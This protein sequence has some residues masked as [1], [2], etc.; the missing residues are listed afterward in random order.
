MRRRESILY[1][2][3]LALVSTGLDCGGDTTY[4]IRRSTL[5]PIPSPSLRPAALA[6]GIVEGS[7]ASDVV[8]WAQPPEAYELRNVGHY[9]PRGQFQG[10]LLFSWHRSVSLGFVWEVGVPQGA[11]PISEWLIAAP[12]DPAWGS[13]FHLS[14]HIPVHERVVIDIGCE[15]LF[16]S[17][18]SRMTYMNCDPDSDEVGSGGERSAT[19]ATLL[20]RLWV[21]VGWDFHWSHL[22]FAF[23][24][25]PHPYN[26]HISREHHDDPSTI[27]PDLEYT[28]YPYVLIGWELHM[29]QWAH[30]SLAV[31]QMLDFDPVVYA[32]IFG[33]NLRFNQ[34]SRG[35]RF[36][37]EEEDDES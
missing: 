28:L 26:T 10:T 24:I 22:T 17:L 8:V 33:L 5:V 23:G 9:V 7:F 35:R 14:F 29:A 31:Y 15:A 20:P 19:T 36:Q 37:P 18:P 25:R 30:I 13:G 3:L 4:C 27:S 6:T 21:A 34:L 16:S 32:P 1:L 11:I 12:D 2:S